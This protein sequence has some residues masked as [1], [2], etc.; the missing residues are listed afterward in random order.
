MIRVLRLQDDLTLVFLTGCASRRQAQ[1]LLQ[2]VPAASPHAQATVPV[3]GRT[4]AHALDR[5][6]GML[7]TVIATMTLV[8]VML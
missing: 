6:L 2:T 5:G 3:A 8:E 4:A 7:F 1:G